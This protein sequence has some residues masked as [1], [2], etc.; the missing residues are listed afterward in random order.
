M[1]RSNSATGL[2]IDIDDTICDTSRTCMRLMAQELGTTSAFDTDTFLEK[3]KFPQFVP[4]WQ[5]QTGE[6]WLIGHLENP[7]FLTTLPPI[8]IAQKFLQKLAATFSITLYLTS[9]DQRMQK[10][11]EN[12][13]HQHNFPLAPVVTRPPHVTSIDWKV[14]FLAQYYPQTLAL[15]DNEVYAPAKHSYQGAVIELQ[16]YAERRNPDHRIISIQ[17]WED[18]ESWLHQHTPH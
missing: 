1:M 16:P 17:T 5:N 13:L 12:W 3:Y 11:T 10:A 4:D 14:T 18:L 6:K 7:E 2:V 9:R 15:I 8:E